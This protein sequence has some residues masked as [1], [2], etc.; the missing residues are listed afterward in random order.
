METNRFILFHKYDYFAFDGEKHYFLDK[1]NNL[2]YVYDNN[3]NKID[4]IAISRNYNTL[5]YDYKEKIFWATTAECYDKIFKLDEK[6]NEI[7]YIEINDICLDNSI[8]AISYNCERDTILF[9]TQKRIYEIYKNTEIITPI[10]TQSIGYIIDIHSLSPNY[11]FITLENF[12][13]YLYIINENNILIDRIVLDSYKEVKSFIYK[14]SSKNDSILLL[15]NGN[16][17][18][19]EIV[20]FMPSSKIDYNSCNKFNLCEEEC[21]DIKCNMIGCISQIQCSIAEVLSAEAKKIEKVIECSCN[22]GDILS[23][24]ESVNETIINVTLLEQMLY[25][26]LK[27]ILKN[28]GENSLCN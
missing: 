2:T 21:I 17:E 13:Y 8:N 5:C 14:P 3:F 20:I 7:A 19:S 4:E 22:I 12:E 10:Y 24:N 6:L 23:I 27:K 15:E 26:K 28:E 18:T 11:L 25:Y 16:L 9:S 1:A